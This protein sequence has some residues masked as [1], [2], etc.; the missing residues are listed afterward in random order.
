M[1]RNVGKIP[2][3]DF[4]CYLLFSCG[5]KD[6]MLPSAVTPFLDRTLQTQRRFA[7]TWLQ[8]PNPVGAQLGALWDRCTDTA[9]CVALMVQPRGATLR[10]LCSSHT[11]SKVYVCKF[12]TDKVVL[13]PDITSKFA[14]MKSGVL[15]KLYL[16]NYSP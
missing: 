9:V 6:S 1:E 12:K 14:S 5:C 8:P 4:L 3:F 7:S 11:Q 13:H 16:T 10:T 2:H 15:D